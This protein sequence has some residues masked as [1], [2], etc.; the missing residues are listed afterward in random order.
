[1]SHAASI[2]RSSKGNP[3]ASLL[4]NHVETQSSQIFACKQPV[5]FG[6]STPVMLIDM[7]VL[8]RGA[9]VWREC[10]KFDAN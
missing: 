9:R 7:L 4:T 10:L 1:M 5:L 6:A 3:F 8:H 2:G